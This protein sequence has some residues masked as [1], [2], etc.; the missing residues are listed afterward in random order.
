MISQASLASSAGSYERGRTEIA[1]A[2]IVC[3]T[4]LQ[5]CPLACRSCDI[6]EA[7]P[8]LKVGG[9]SF[10][11]AKKTLYDASKGPA[12]SNSVVFLGRAKRPVGEAEDVPS[13]PVEDDAKE[14]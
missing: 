8:Q 6:C 3:G 1:T 9:Y 14:N 5:R 7:A 10:R 4:C 13:S 12:L 2:S 11:G